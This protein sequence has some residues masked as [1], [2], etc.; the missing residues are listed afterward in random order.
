M[1]E[2]PQSIELDTVGELAGV[3]DVVGDLVASIRPHQWDA[4]TPCPDWTVRELVA[5]LVLGHRLFAGILRGSAVVTPTALD[6]LAGDVLGDDP[7]TEYRAATGD[8]L[9][10]F[11]LPGALEGVVEVPFGAVPGV[12]AANLRVVEELVHGWDLARAIG[13]PVRFADDAV[14]HALGFTLATLPEV[15]AEE[16]P[17]APAQPTREDAPPLDRLAALLGRNPEHP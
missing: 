7:A 10:A 1:T 14:E 5:H 16:S 15:P 11:R 6:P 2:Q 9:A 12:V 3:L 13:M 17:F 4:A 8:L